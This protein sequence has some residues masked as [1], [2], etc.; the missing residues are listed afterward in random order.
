MLFY[1]AHSRP[2]LKDYERAY[3]KIEIEIEIETNLVESFRHQNDMR[4]ATGFIFFHP[5]LS[6]KFSAKRRKEKKISRRVGT[7]SVR[8]WIRVYTRE[9]KKR[10]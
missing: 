7:V 10:N 2:P 8:T 6:Q 5:S 3:S 4:S 9:K 1:S